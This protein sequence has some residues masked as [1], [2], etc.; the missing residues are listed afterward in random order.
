MSCDEANP[1]IEAAAVGEAGAGRRW[2]A[3]LDD[4]RQ[5][6]VRGLTLAQRI[7]LALAAAAGR[8]RRPGFTAVGHAPAATR[9]L[10]RR[11]GRRLRVQRAR[12]RSASSIIAPGLA[13]AA[14]G[15]AGVRARFERGG[16]GKLARPI[17]AAARRAARRRR[18]TPR[19]DRDAAGDDG[20]R[21]CG[22]GRRRRRCRVRGRGPR[23]GGLAAT[24]APLRAGLADQILLD[25]TAAAALRLIARRA[26][27]RW[28]RRPARRASMLRS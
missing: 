24:R 15:G 20:G 6:R 2:R 25:R 17:G 21:G 18:I 8:R 7:D 10:A 16:R 27:T 12:L 13:G 19:D 23:T 14:R 28:A 3:H 22:G 1:F 11:A 4:C 9:T 26:G 5:C